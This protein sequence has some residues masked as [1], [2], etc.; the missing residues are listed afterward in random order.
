M[1]HVRRQRIAGGFLA[2]VAISENMLRD[3]ITAWTLIAR[4]PSFHAS[5]DRHAAGRGAFP[6]WLKGSLAFFASNHMLGFSRI[7]RD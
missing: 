1:N 3:R 6:S 2:A 7:A 5:H 4:P